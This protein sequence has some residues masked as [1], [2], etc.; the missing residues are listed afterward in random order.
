MSTTRGGGGG[1]GVGVTITVAV[2]FPVSPPVSF[3]SIVILYVPGTAN[4]CCAVASCDHGVSQTP[5]FSQS[6]RIW[7]RFDGSWASNEVDVNVKTVDGSPLAGVQLKFAY[8][9]VFV[10]GGGGGGGGKVTVTLAIADG[11]PALSHACASIRLLPD[12][13]AALAVQSTSPAAAYHPSPETR[14]FTTRRP[15]PPES[16]AIPVTAIDEAFT[17]APSAGDVIPTSGGTVSSWGGRI[18]GYRSAPRTW[19]AYGMSPIPSG[20]LQTSCPGPLHWSA[21]R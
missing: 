6:H 8:G 2:W 4:W 3:T 1:G 7:S 19:I 16:E 11:L 13:S 21:P 12:T 5:L 17:V 15:L 14:T 10:G 18:K 20:P 9:G